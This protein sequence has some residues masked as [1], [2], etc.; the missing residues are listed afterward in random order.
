MQLFVFACDI[1]LSIS[2]LFL[3]IT[4]FFT[5]RWSN[6]RLLNNK[7]VDTVEQKGGVYECGLMEN[8]AFKQ[9]YI[10][11]SDE[12]IKDRLNAHLQGRGNSMIA[13]KV[14]NGS[15]V[16]F[17][18]IYTNNGAETEANLLNRYGYGTGKQYEWNERIEH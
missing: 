17:R 12:S 14:R 9:R 7:N 5:M 11:Q 18:C 2:Y 10:G 13:R 3:N 8:G 1:L 6:P 15:L 4:A 16:Y